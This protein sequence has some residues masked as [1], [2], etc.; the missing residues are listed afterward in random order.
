[1]KNELNEIRR[2][3][4]ETKAQLGTTSLVPL[5][6]LIDESGAETGL[7]DI[8]GNPA[9][10]SENSVVMPGLEKPFNQIFEGKKH[11]LQPHARGSGI[12]TTNVLYAIGQALNEP[13][14]IIFIRESQ[15]SIAESVHATFCRFI[16]ENDQL[17]D[18]F[19]IQRDKIIGRNGSEILFKG[20]RTHNMDSL[21]SYENLK[22]CFGD[23]CQSLSLESIETIIFTVRAPG[24]R[25]FWSYNPRKATDPIHKMFGDGDRPD[26][27]VPREPYTLFDNPFLSEELR[28]EAEILRKRDPER[29][30]HVALG[31]IMTYSEA[32]I[33]H[34]FI[35]RPIN[36][37][38]VIEQRKKIIKIGHHGTLRE[39]RIRRR[40]K[41]EMIEASFGVGV[42]FG[43]VDPFV[44]VL[45]YYD[46]DYNRLFILNEYYKTGLDPDGMVNALKSFPLPSPKWPIY[47]DHAPPLIAY[48]WKHGFNA[49]PATKLPVLDRLHRL[50]E[51]E[52]IISPDCPH[53][54]EEFGL[55]SWRRDAQ[56][57]V[58]ADQPEDSNDH[59]IDS[60]AYSLGARLKSEKPAG[61]Y[62]VLAESWP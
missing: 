27:S 33:L 1:M 7:V 17:R 61:E 16:R 57:V 50:M 47:C 41:E 12:T 22:F 21:R 58:I 28:Q 29:F 55:Y 26:T 4:D 15:G 10:V 38:A 60:I 13:C 11:T 62:K 24:T 39:Q 19:T 25:Y 43:T 48:I 54:I 37:R 8:G 14:R 5:Y 23:E 30:N 51:L 44:I 3:I 2:K 40:R 32:R 45:T 9:E 52:I 49:I 36:I 42:D 18:F 35:I 46:E 20:V 6:R 34:R 31:H 56:G 59:I 53:T